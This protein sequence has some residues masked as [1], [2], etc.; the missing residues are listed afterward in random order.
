MGA[1]YERILAKM[2]QA[3]WAP[4]REPVRIGRGPLIMIVLRHGLSA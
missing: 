4:P 2:E 3:G 1:V